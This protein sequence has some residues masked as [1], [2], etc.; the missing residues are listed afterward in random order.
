MQIA[1]FWLK[2]LPALFLKKPWYPCPFEILEEALEEICENYWSFQ[3]IVGGRSRPDSTVTSIQVLQVQIPEPDPCTTAT[4]PNKPKGR[5]TKQPAY[6][7]Y[8]CNLQK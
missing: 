4:Q 1:L 8:I 6:V 3:W 5:T 7:K 2:L